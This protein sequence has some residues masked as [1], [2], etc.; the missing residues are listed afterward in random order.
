MWKV[1]PC[2]WRRISA[3]TAASVSPATSS[4]MRADAAPCAPFTARNALVMAT[5]ILAGS[6]PTTAPFLRITLYSAYAPR[7]AASTGSSAPGARTA[8]ALS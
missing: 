5:L 4:R 8:V 3:P 1:P 2:G 6:K 7:A